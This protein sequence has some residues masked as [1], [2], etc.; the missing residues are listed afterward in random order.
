MS[1]YYSTFRGDQIVDVVRYI[2]YQAFVIAAPKY[3]LLM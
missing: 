2:P 3:I 1:G